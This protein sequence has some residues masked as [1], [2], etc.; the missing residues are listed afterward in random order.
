[1]LSQLLEKHGIG[2]RVAAFDAASREAIGSLDVADLAMVCV[3][4]LDISGNPPHLRYLIKRLRQ[5]LPKVPIVVGLWSSNE[6]WSEEQKRLIGA[7]SYTTS[8]REAIDVCVKEATR[9]PEDA[10]PRRVK[11]GGVVGEGPTS[12]SAVVPFT[13]RARPSGSAP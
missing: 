3:S 6:S 2:A 5:R 4:Y 8:L 10:N 11:R 13:S 9:K 12:A 7:D 1:M